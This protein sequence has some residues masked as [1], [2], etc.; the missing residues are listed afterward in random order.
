MHFA[1]IIFE[2]DYSSLIDVVGKVYIT[3]RCAWFCFLKCGYEMLM[4][5]YR[6]F[7][8]AHDLR[9]AVY[10]QLLLIQLYL[11]PPE[12]RQQHAVTH[13]HRQRN[14]FSVVVE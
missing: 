2:N 10:V 1:H 12:L 4:N 6:S 14:N 13:L 7:Q 3:Y 5:K 9:I 8:P 11:L